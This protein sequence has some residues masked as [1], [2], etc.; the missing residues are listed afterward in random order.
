MT[1]YISSTS[2]E[3]NEC[4]MLELYN[5]C[6][7][8]IGSCTVCRVPEVINVTCATPNPNKGNSVPA[9]STVLTVPPCQACFHRSSNVL[10]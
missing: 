3:T 5:L 9:L 6:V 7:S 2:N 10:P 8:V 4:Y 1:Q